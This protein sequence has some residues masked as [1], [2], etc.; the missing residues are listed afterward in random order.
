MEGA[1]SAPVAEG[2]VVD[3]KG[4]FADIEE[5]LNRMSKQSPKWVTTEIEV[6]EGSEA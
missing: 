5:I 3:L 6:P 2:L 1:E 4:F